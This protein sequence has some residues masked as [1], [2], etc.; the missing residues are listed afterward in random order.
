M[1][2]RFGLS[3]DK[4][5][6]RFMYY[7]SVV[8]YFSD[9]ISQDHTNAFFY[10]DG[11]VDLKPVRNA[12]GQLTGLE[13][14][15]SQEFAARAKRHDEAEIAMGASGIGEAG[16]YEGGDPALSDDSLERYS[17]FGVSYNEETKNYLYEGKDI[18]YF[19]DPNGMA[20]I[21]YGVTNGVA[22]KVVRGKNHKIEKIVRMTADEIKEALQ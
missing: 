11:V 22:I 21:N 9:P 14:A 5:K 15:S 17:E 19:Y 12:S 8:R 18:Y 10:K 3:Y 20:Y 1:Y 7:G 13:V 6:D 4:D 2:Q 16:C